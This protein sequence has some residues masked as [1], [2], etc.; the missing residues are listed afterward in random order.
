MDK[1]Q[2]GEFIY[3]DQK[4]RIEAAGYA[5]WR[6]K[7][8]PN[9]KVAI[10]TLQNIKKGNFKIDSILKLGYEIEVSYSIKKGVLET[11]LQETSIESSVINTLGNPHFQ[12]E[13]VSE[14]LQAE[15][16]RRM[17]AKQDWGSFLA[18]LNIIKPLTE[19]AKKRY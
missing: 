12:Y 6:D 11:M 9:Y 7:F 4:K 8:P 5:I 19:E 14:L 13:E 17:E 15:I 18:I 3:A 10:S 1:K 2:L 16:T